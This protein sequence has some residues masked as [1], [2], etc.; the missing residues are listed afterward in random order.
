M[1]EKKKNRNKFTAVDH[2]MHSISFNENYHFLLPFT[3]FQRLD[4]VSPCCALSLIHNF[5][6][7]THRASSLSSLSPFSVD[8]APKSLMKERLLASRRMRSEPINR[9][10][11]TE[12]REPREKNITQIKYKLVVWHFAL[13]FDASYAYASV[14]PLSIDA[15][16]SIEHAAS[17][18][19][20]RNGFVENIW[21]LVSSSHTFNPIVIDVMRHIL[22]CRRVSQHQSLHEM[23]LYGRQCLESRSDLFAICNTFDVRL[24]IAFAFGWQRNPIKMV[25]ESR[26][27]EMEWP[28]KC[29]SK[30]SAEWAVGQIN[31]IK[32]KYDDWF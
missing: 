23:T 29:R 14:S 30:R 10:R 1:G 9:T 24:K 12:M 22:Q 13:T 4:A 26:S 21:Q 2:V 19:S 25:Q 31:L 15:H 18:H 16:A 17:C 27:I 20:R 8:K 11:Y 32:L 5:F 28:N 3:V 6:C 7:L